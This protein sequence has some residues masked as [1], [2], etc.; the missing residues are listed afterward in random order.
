MET[1]TSSPPPGS[2]P[3]SESRLAADGHKGEV[4]LAAAGRLAHLRAWLGAD[5]HGHGVFLVAAGGTST[6]GPGSPLMA[7]EAASFS[8]SPEASLV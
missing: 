6:Y 3:T 5:G 8:P 2:S 7:K 4:P 1:A